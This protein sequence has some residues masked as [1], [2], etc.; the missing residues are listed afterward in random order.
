[1]PPR[2][3]P[4]APPRPPPPTPPPWPGRF[5]AKVGAG[6]ASGPGAALPAVVGVAA[7][8]VAGAGAEAGT[9]ATGVASGPLGFAG[10]APPCA[11]GPTL[12]DGVNA[13]P[14][15]GPAMTGQPAADVGSRW[16]SSTACCLVM[17][18]PLNWPITVDG[19]ASAN[20]PM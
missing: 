19:E 11:A 3:P 20:E 13:T 17:S 7:A 2:P 12:V 14:P 5:D 9:L 8:G 15:F 18:R 10:A 16:S 6:A 4:P 1:L